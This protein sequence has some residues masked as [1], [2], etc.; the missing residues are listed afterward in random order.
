ML[1]YTMFLQY[2]NKVLANKFSLIV[3]FLLIFKL[4]ITQFNH[5]IFFIIFL[6]FVLSIIEFKRI[7]KINIVIILI[8]IVS[9]PYFFEKKTIIESHGIFLP[10][11]NNKYV[12]IEEQIVFL[13]TTNNVDL[14][15]SKDHEINSLLIREFYNS[16]ELDDLYCKNQINRCWEDVNI[17]KIFSRSFDQIKFGN[18]NYSRKV[19]N[20]N[21]SSISNI[22]IGN[23]N[24][25]EMN[26]YNH[27]E[28]WWN[29][30]DSN[31]IK[32]INAPFIVQY[33]FPG[34]K[35]SNSEICWQGNAIINDKPEII[36]NEMIS[37]K[38]IN[39]NFKI[40]FFNF[41]NTLKVKLDKSLSL[42]FTDY[43]FEL[44]KILS[45]LIFSFII[46]KRIDVIKI[47]NYSIISLFSTVSIAYTIFTR[48]EFLFGY[49]PLQGGMDGL[50][51]EGYGRLIYENFLNLNFIEALKG[52]EGIYYFMPGLRYFTA[53]EKLFF[54]DNQFGIFLILILLPIIFYIFLLELKFSQRFS[55]LLILSFIIFKIPHLGFSYNH[56]IRNL[57]T[58]YPETLAIL[59]FFICT[60]FLL[61]KKY[62]LSGFSCAIMVFLRP[63]YFPT[64]LAINFFNLILSLR[65]KDTKRLTIFLLG[66]SFLLAMPFHNY[67]FG[68]KVIV[69]FVKGAGISRLNIHPLQYLY[70]FENYDYYL[71]IITHLKNLLTTGMKN[72]IIVYFVNSILLSN[73]ILYFLYNFKKI[74]N[75]NWFFC[76]IS[77]LQITPSFFYDNT[78]RYAYFSWLLITISNILIIREYYFY[79]KKTSYQQVL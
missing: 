77:L 42:I 60:V 64:F 62:F 52:G 41:N 56:Y 11:S 43:T 28:Q 10:S 55:I 1:K 30:E 50:V 74:N 63:N 75:Y 16:Y 17:K 59:S 26:W 76:L 69:F 40:L 67:I 38:K 24:I 66:S 15:I 61:K 44:L 31:K 35:Y 49:Q 79:Y 3:I 13:P 8:L 27:S 65:N 18:I 47:L 29:K 73:L 37:C 19:N 2:F 22:R 78:D 53:L 72:N 9:L 36:Y 23:I 21:H 46:V 34:S 5:F 14:Y 7:K 71:K 33:V 54:G 4:P 25:H 48:K 6:L 51:H 20:I 12:D 57:L 68:E 39:A 32:R 70:M 45:L 58:V